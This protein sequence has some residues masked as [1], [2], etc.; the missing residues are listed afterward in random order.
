LI[1]FDDIPSEKGQEV[2]DVHSD[3]GQQVKPVPIASEDFS[4]T[5]DMDVDITSNDLNMASPKMPARN[6]LLASQLANSDA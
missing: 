4:T 5:E 2:N 3:K 6:R 1:S